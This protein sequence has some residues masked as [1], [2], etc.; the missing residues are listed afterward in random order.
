MSNTTLFTEF[1]FIWW[2]S[3]WGSLMSK[4]RRI[5]ILRSHKHALIFPSGFRK[6][7]NTLIVFLLAIIGWPS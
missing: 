4:V 1:H 2:P 3:F 5:R 7:F 6:C